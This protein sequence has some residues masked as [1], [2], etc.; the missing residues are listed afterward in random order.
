MTSVFK[1][2]FRVLGYAC[3]AIAIV[4]GISDASSSIALS[5]VELQPLGKLL[6]D[7]FPDSFPILQPAIERH[8][9]PALWDPGI[10]TVLT[11]PVWAFFAPLG[12]LFLWIGARSRRQTVQFA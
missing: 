2:L 6:F 1:F 8:I 12:L 5:Q 9:H 11:W 4:A 3:I 10:L 7:L